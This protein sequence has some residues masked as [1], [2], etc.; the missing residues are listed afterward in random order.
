M[1]FLVAAVLCLSLLPAQDKPKSALDK[2]QLEAYVR[3]LLAVIPEVQIKID[4]PK[5]SEIP[6][7]VSVDVHFTY[8]TRSQDETFLVTKDGK[9]IVR[10]VVYDFGKNPFQEDLAKLKTD[11]APTYGSASAPVTL[12]VFGDFECPNC[13]GEAQELREN[14]LKTFPTQARVVFKDFPLESIHPWAKPAAIA[15][16]CIYDQ[17]P[18]AFWKYHDWIY[19]HQ[20][21]ITPD[22]FKD[23]VLEF[24]KTAP[25]VDSL[26]LGHCMDTKATETQV[27]AS[28][29]QGH[30]LGVDATP[31]LFINGRRLVGN[32]PWQNIEQIINGEVSY[33]KTEQ[34]GAKAPATD[35]SCCEVKIPSPLNAPKSAQ[36][37]QGVIK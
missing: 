35:D 37:Q 8:G 9:H 7:M 25:E 14:L 26:Q 2:P 21:E 5:P 12:V 23:K 18:A 11:S 16:R 36:P 31:T 3:H 1:R 24:A 4:D 10:G 32:Y 34:A 27:D 19:E 6:N 15:G 20:E 30:S 22:N 33:Q 28:I 29:A 17:N 13:K